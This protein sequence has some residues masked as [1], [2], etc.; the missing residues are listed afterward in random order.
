[1]ISL[2]EEYWE[3]GLQACNGGQ[4]ILDAKKSAQGGNPIVRGQNLACFDSYFF[5]GG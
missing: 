5:S 2:S 3:E 4:E 1:L